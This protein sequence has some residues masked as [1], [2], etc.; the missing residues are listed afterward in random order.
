MAT[1]NTAGRSTTTAMSGPN[2]II[3]EHEVVNGKP[4]D[5]LIANVHQWH[6]SVTL[7]NKEILELYEAIQG[8]LYGRWEHEPRQ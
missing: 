3:K 7:D 4:K 5:S 1:R 2:E 8:I 6:N